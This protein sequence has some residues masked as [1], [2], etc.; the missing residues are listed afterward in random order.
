MIGFFI[1]QVYIATFFLNGTKS[2]EMSDIFLQKR[3]FLSSLGTQNMCRSAGIILKTSEMERL[4]NF[5]SKLCPN[6]SKN[7]FSSRR[8]IILKKNLDKFSGKFRFLLR[9]FWIFP[10]K[11]LLGK[12]KFSL[13]KIENF[14]FFFR[15][16][17]QNYFSPRWKN[18]FRLDFFKPQVEY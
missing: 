1:Y 2:Y 8:K 9:K 4:W 3:A 10:V 11:F 18:I 15:D 17:F 16:F 14:Q 5:A 13:V 6:L 7:I 12:F